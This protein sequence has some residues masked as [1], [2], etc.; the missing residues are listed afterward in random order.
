MLAALVVH[1]LGRG[2]RVSQAGAAASACRVFPVRL[3]DGS[4][5]PQVRPMRMPGTVE[6][7]GSAAAPS[8]RDYS[9]PGR[10]PAAF[11]A[12]VVVLALF[13]ALLQAI[14][15]WASSRASATGTTAGNFI[16]V[17]ARIYDSRS[18][19]P[20]AANTPRSIQVTGVGGI[21]SSGV[22]AVEV[23]LIAVNYTASCDLWA[24]ADGAANPGTSALHFSTAYT[25][26]VSNTAIV[27]VN[28]S[29]GKIEVSS[30]AQTNVIIDA[31]GYYTSGSSTAAGGYV[32]VT[33]S[34]IADT[35]NGTGSVSQAKLAAGGT[36]NIQV[37]G[38]GGVPTGTAMPSSAFVNITVINTGASSGSYITAYP[39]GGSV[40]GTAM[41]Y[42]ASTYTAIGATVPLDQ[43]SG[44]FSIKLPTSAPAPVDV[45]VDIEGYFSASATSDTFVSYEKRI[46]DSR[47]TTTFAANEVR[48]VSIAG[49]NGVPAMSSGMS[50]GALEVHVQ[51]S[52]TASGYV[53]VFK[54]DAADP[55]LNSVNFG[56]GG[57]DRGGLVVSALGADGGVK[58]KNSSGSTVDVLIDIEG[59][60]VGKGTNAAP[61]T[62]GAPSLSPA[63][64]SSGVNYATSLKPTF[65]VTDTDPNG[66]KYSQITEVHSS[67]DTTSSTL[68]ASC[69]SGTVS[70][71]AAAPCTLANSLADGTTY[72]ATTRATDSYGKANATY[73]T[74]QTFTTAVATP[75]KPSISCPASYP[76]GSWANSVPSSAQACTV[77]ASGSAS[78]TS[79]KKV[80]VT[81]DAGKP[82]DTTI[83]TSGG[84]ATA[85]VPNTPGQHTI[86]ATTT[87]ASGIHSAAVTYKVGWGVPN[88][89]SPTT[90]YRTLG[91]TQIVAAAPPRGTASIVAAK[92]Q[93]RLSDGN[94]GPWQTAVGDTTVTN[95]DPAA[96]TSFSSNWDS[97]QATSYTEGSTTLTLSTRHSILLDLRACF[98]YDGTSKCTTDNGTAPTTVLRVPSA[99]GDGFPTA[100]A[101]EGSVAL[102][103]GEFSTSATDV[104]VTTNEG[105]LTI[106]RSHSTFAN[107]SSTAEGVFGSGW[108]ADFEGDGAG[109]S[110]D[111]IDD[112]TAKDGSVSFIASDG[113]RLTYRTENGTAGADPQVTYA[114]FDTPSQEAEEKVTIN[115]SGQL[116]MTDN[117]GTVTTW[118]QQTPGDPTTWVPLSVAE[119][120]EQGTTTY[121]TDGQG[122]VT[123]IL[124]P[125][126]AGVTCP[127]SGTLNKG[128]SALDLT[129]ATQTTATTGI[130]GDYAGQVQFVNF[131]TW[132]PDQ[133][134]MAHITMAR[135]AYDASGRLI[136]E[137]NPTDVNLNRSTTYTYAA[138]SA[139]VIE[140]S[141]SSSTGYATYTYDYDSSY[142]LADVKRGAAAAG[143]STATLS[144]YVYNAS[145]GVSGPDL[146]AATISDWDQTRTP[147]A[148][149]AVFGAD[150]PVTGTPA[151]SDWP[152]ATLYYTD[153]DGYEVNS[154]DYGAGQ[155][156]INYNNYDQDGNLVNSLHPGDI[157]TAVA[158]AS[159]G[160]DYV[161]NDNSTVTRFYAQKSG[162]DPGNPLIPADTLVED[163]WSAPFL[164]TTL[165][166]SQSEVRTHTHFQYDQGAPNADIDPATGSPYNLV[167]TTTTGTSGVADTTTDPNETLPDDVST[168]SVERNT[169]DPL[170]SSSP[171][172][173]QSGWSL[174]QPT[175][176]TT[177]LDSDPNDDIT[178]KT[179][180]DASGN[181]IAALAPGSTG[182]DAG[183]TLTVA[184]TAGANGQRSEC[185]N[186]AAWVGLPCWV[187]PSAQPPSGSPI[188]ATSYPSYNKW[189]EPLSKVET[190]GNGVNA[191]T[192][193]TTMTYTS[194]GRAD[195]T[196]T[197]V[198][199]LQ[200]S[201]PVAATR[202]LYDAI[203]DAGVG[204]A[205]L[206]SDGSVASQSVGSFDLWGRP[207]KYVNSLGD[208][209][210]TTYVASGVAGAG[211][212]ATVTNRSGYSTYSYDG[213]DAAGK[214]EHRGLATG[215][216]ITGAGAYAAAY[217]ADGNLS[218]QKLPAGL[219]ETY[220]YDEDGKLTHLSYD[221]E[222]P[223]GSTAPWVEYSRSYNFA[224]QPSADQASVNIGDSPTT[225]SRGYSYDWAGRLVNVQDGGNV[226]AAVQTC[227]VRG[228]RF[229][230]RGN[231]T[232]LLAGQA[233][234]T[235]CPTSLQTTSYAYDGFSRQVT[236]A[237]GSGSYV[238]DQLGRQT[239]LPA[240]DDADRSGDTATTTYFD[241]DSVAGIAEGSGSDTFTLDPN[242]RRLTDTRT[243]PASTVITSHYGD[244][245][246]SPAWD[247]AVTST[248]TVTTEFLSTLDP[249][250]SVQL[251]SSGSDVTN[252]LEF[253]DLAGNVSARAIVPSTGNATNLSGLASYDEYGATLSSTL[254][255]VGSKYAAFGQFQRATTESGLVL[256][257]ARLYN[258]ATGRFTSTDHRPDGNENAYNYPNNPVGLND[259]SGDSTTYMEARSPWGGY[260][261]VRLEDWVV[262]KIFYGIDSAGTKKWNAHKGQWDFLRR[263]TW[264]VYPSTRAFMTSVV[265]AALVHWSKADYQAYN[266][267]FAFEY[268]L[269]LGEIDWPYFWRTRQLGYQ[270][271]RVVVG[272][273]KCSSGS[274][275]IVTAYPQGRFKFT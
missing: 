46:F 214:A 260:F 29:T 111:Q 23:S 193:T 133:A 5:M 219:S 32:P 191:T 240:S 77:T 213:T 201:V 99:F 6:R 208:V 114:P 3:D 9:R 195:S 126:P 85:T 230:Q 197:S 113:S 40:P 272:L 241:N 18:L 62:P 234:G 57:V 206:N 16:P 175:T 86:T 228:Y 79:P 154:A 39:T 65:S 244:T 31:Q 110:G 92:L 207:V 275:N 239:T 144:T 2:R 225:A 253:S 164:A 147:T 90:T 26:A 266:D 103:T 202:A 172:G 64:S 44:Q 37:A 166:G 106:S 215:L 232:A 102:W 135:Y 152:Y 268:R 56:S 168:I 262:N 221:G 198:S 250:V 211:Q 155:W 98:T 87:S 116:T 97:R 243:A 179:V 259:L 75:A 231:R 252:S 76:A 129:Y 4:G 55:G 220:E 128:C 148:T 10:R 13:V 19:T 112:E 217:N 158:D 27:P 47:S 94:N 271:I 80:T 237:N 42:V 115:S 149:Y 196:S 200:S 84:S 54:D 157:N 51:P 130:P 21:P 212:V 143:G 41:D 161:A 88:I 236:G 251:Q 138:P 60:Y 249:R 194:D 48:T 66:D 101:G 187:G 83:G 119:A 105:S 108:V 25:S 104:N 58:I 238:Y 257:G 33:P 246:D 8:T 145:P 223:D 50:V 52:S 181:V 107:P 167:T 11:V 109:H 265:R 247:T 63:T 72:Y 120:G 159:A 35:R 169:Y 216:T 162:A 7:A 124:A 20:L 134:V 222:M 182:S 173:A 127:S 121:T 209:T 205:A 43:S 227:S 233:S 267:T 28:T 184:Y 12:I 188:P 163:T 141:G 146:S 254:S 93:W 68:V 69:H 256:M 150:H 170:D 123:R 224:N 1:V 139:G 82:A 67:K 125:V 171:T 245:T 17:T 261:N 204:T 178:R 183:T 263:Q 71:A 180:Y 73:S 122:R 15:P 14:A 176:A 49:V 36:L 165:D 118:R 59:W 199:G 34:R 91:P 264:N 117:D 160:V 190:S 153:S 30:C 189:L 74:W 248:S 38:L 274:C 70:S 177:E 100:D 242:S 22:S 142:R 226:G 137:T 210:V 229:D 132:D 192:R 140:L 96:A 151:A 81:I 218:M 255:S 273:S 235:A 89:T 156:L 53:E 185:G 270:W 61:A 78:A 258:P 95:S 24:A 131:E 136:T 174:R 203:T 269:V 45:I 186:Q